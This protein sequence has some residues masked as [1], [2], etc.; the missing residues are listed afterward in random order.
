[1]AYPILHQMK[2]VVLVFTILFLQD[3][4]VVQCLLVSVTSIA[5]MAFLGYH[6]PSINNSLNKSGIFDEY[7]TL[8]VMDSLLVSSDPGLHVDMRNEIGLLLIGLLGIAILAGQVPILVKNCKVLKTKCKAKCV[9][10]G[11]QR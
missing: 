6:K 5:S 4:L 3:Y 2:L 11:R 1:M 9:K 10:K 7:L 8:L